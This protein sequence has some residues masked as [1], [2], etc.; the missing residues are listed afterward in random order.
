[1]TYGVG[2]PVLVVKDVALEGAPLNFDLLRAL[3]GKKFPL[4]WQGDITGTVRGRGGPLNRFRV[5]ESRIH[6][7]GC[8]RSGCDQSR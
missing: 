2:G 8:A 7:C 1:M 3:N 5:D 6:V 4:D